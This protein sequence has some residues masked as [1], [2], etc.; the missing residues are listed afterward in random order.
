MQCSNLALYLF[1]HNTYR[2]SS[3]RP[4]QK[5]ITIRWRSWNSVKASKEWCHC[6]RYTQHIQSIKSIMKLYIIIIYRV[7]AFTLLKIFP[8]GGADQNTRKK[9]LFTS[10][11]AT[12]CALRDIS[13]GHAFSISRQ[14][15]II[16]QRRAMRVLVIL[17]LQASLLW[18]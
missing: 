15:L 3:F 9:L 5:I 17:R 13:D 10:I 2:F 18:S 6:T 16:R 8:Y 12:L 11:F 4:A 1:L 14:N 7:L